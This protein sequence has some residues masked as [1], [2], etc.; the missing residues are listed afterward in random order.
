[1]IGCIGEALEGG[2]EIH[3]GHDPELED[4]RW[5]DMDVVREALGKARVM[6][7]DK[8]KGGNDAEAELRVPTAT[9]IAH[10]LMLAAV[11]EAMQVEAKI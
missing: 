3:L 8:E 4:A 7:G 1:M 5:F 2:D 10:Q 11:N 6:P 9:A